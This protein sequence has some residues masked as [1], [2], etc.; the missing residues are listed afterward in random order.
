MKR[1]HE[2]LDAAA[3]LPRCMKS[4]L[5]GALSVLQLPL[6]VPDNEE[7]RFNQEMVKLSVEGNQSHAVQ[8]CL[9]RVDKLQ[10]K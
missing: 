9:D 2:L 1:L 3:G 10:S 8:V 5:S 4:V 7:T 6:S